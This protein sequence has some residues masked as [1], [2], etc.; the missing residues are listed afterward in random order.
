MNKMTSR[1]QAAGFTIVELIV[2]IVVIG[3]LVAI[4]SFSYRA[5][6]EKTYFSTIATNL[7][8][9]NAAVE[10]YYAK[11]G[12]YPTTGGSWY[13]RAAVN[14]PPNGTNFIP[15]LVSGGYYTGEL[16]D[17]VT[18]SK[19]NVWTNTYIYRSNGADYKLVRLIS[20]MSA[21]EQ[22]FVDSKLI[23][24][25]RTTTGWG[26]WTTGAQSW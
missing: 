14:N 13:Y 11:N 2:V 10:S 22:G 1:V 26:Y 23:D 5:T 3:I 18:G 24:P 21:S 25:A 9:M 20:P 6:Q 15:G 4:V 12:S 17:V 19:T 16:P 7:K 8:A